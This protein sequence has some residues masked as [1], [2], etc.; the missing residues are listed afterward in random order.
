[1]SAH[2]NEGSFG[3]TNIGFVDQLLVGLSIVAYGASATQPFIQTDA[4][5]KLGFEALLLIATPPWWANPL[6]IAALA[7]LFM[8]RWHWTCAPAVAAL[9]LAL[10]AIPLSTAA[11][12]QLGDG[13][14]LWIASMLLLNVA[15]LRLRI[16]VKELTPAS[17]LPRTT[18]VHG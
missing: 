14:L 8:D 3:E 16:T 12:Y 17:S 7:M 6:A 4:G 11:G 9:A 10:S 2:T 18:L 5:S 13:Y 1:M 15:A